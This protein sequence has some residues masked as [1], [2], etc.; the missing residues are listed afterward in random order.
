MKYKFLFTLLL[1]GLA[2][3]SGED[4]FLSGYDLTWESMTADPIYPP[5]I[6]H[7]HAHRFDGYY[8][9]AIMGN[10]LLGTNFYK[11]EDN[12]YRLN[13][14]RSDV[15]EVRDAA[16]ST[17]HTGRLP[18]GYFALRTAG[19]V[20]KE[21]MR[22][23]LHD[24]ITTGHI[25][26]DSGS[27][28]FKTYVHALQE[29]IVFE[30]RTEGEEKNYSWEFVPYQ[31]ISPCYLYFA[32]NYR[33]KSHGPDPDYIRADGRTNP[34][35]WQEDYRGAHLLIQ[36]LAADSTFTT[37]NRYYVVAWKESV[38]GS[39][40]QVI[41]T[42]SQDSDVQK[43]KDRA[44]ADVLNAAK[45]RELEKNHTAWWHQ[46]YA[47]IAHL[48]F[49]DEQIQRFYWMQCYK[50]ASTGRP[51]K[52]IVDL[53]GVWPVYDTPWPAIWMNLNI[54]LT[55]SWQTKLGMGSFV[56]PLLD[57]LWTNRANLIRNVTD[58]P[59]QEDWTECMAIP[60]HCS[61]QLLSRLDPTLAAS[62]EYE[63][64]NLIWTL[65]YCH[66]LCEA[67]GD[68][69]QMR[70]RVFPLLKGAVNLFFRIRTV[71]ADG[72]YGLPPT[73]S[74]EYQEGAEGIG[75]NTNYDLANLKWGLRTLIDLDTRYGINDPLL[76]A[77][78]DFL[79]HLVPF[80][81]N[82][83]TGF[84]VSDKYEFLLTD[85][86]HYSH[87]FM[88]FPYHML[89]W[90][91]PVDSIRMSRSLD[92]WNGN[93]GYSRSGKASMLCARGGKGDGDLALAQIKE[94]L[95]KRI[96]HNT[97]Y[98]ESGPVIETP[99]SAM[100]SL[101]DMYLQDW[102]GVIRIFR[103]CPESW[104]DCSFSNMRA[105]GAFI[106]SAERKEGKTVSVRIKSEKG[107]LC[108]LEI[109]RGKPLEIQTSAGEVI[110]INL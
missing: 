22:L 95:D 66:Q 42:V 31:A 60:R 12:A 3:C 48:R 74:P 89:D 109:D 16:F 68:D 85:H 100:C 59:G 70:E 1:T 29:A 99:F 15:T 76:P 44:L 83:E 9:G 10:G 102:G 93:Q 91:N 71:N 80:R 34:D 51:D 96:T 43:A 79:E 107:G 19:R 97:L 64:G 27:I 7:N 49:P 14:G 87:L 88:I 101:E 61:Y 36:P 53:Q 77:W 28:Q 105:S 23:H 8:D 57:A 26:T 17:Y 30:A 46:F 98:N 103:G 20:Q 13:V 37:I 72:S 35:P 45:S 25:Y 94:L 32:G 75:P 55:Y 69:A 56:Q 40:R 54:Q 86:R 18:I 21:D 62:N 2:A 90:G 108:H 38:K 92:R 47:G 58:N 106:V 82:E 5:G 11:L 39:T 104:K 50:F 52:P 4:D 110:E 81:Y 24:A 65:F 67:C 73:A 78:E 41:A 6:K 33:R 63:A 84:K